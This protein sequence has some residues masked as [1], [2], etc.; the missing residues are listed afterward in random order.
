MLCKET[1]SERKIHLV[2]DKWRKKSG[3]QPTTICDGGLGSTVNRGLSAVDKLTMPELSTS[4]F[5]KIEV[6]S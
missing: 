5:N 1:G 4:G 6:N 3:Q 2:L